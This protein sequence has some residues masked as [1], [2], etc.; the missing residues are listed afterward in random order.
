MSWVPPGSTNRLNSCSEPQ[1]ENSTHRGSSAKPNRLRTVAVEWSRSAENVE[2]PPVLAVPSATDRRCPSVPTTRKTE[3]RSSSLRALV[4]YRPDSVETQNSARRNAASNAE[5]RNWPCGFSSPSG[6]SGK[7]FGSA[8]DRTT[9]RLLALTSHLPLRIRIFRLGADSV[10]TSWQSSFAGTSASTSL[11]MA[12][13]AKGMEMCKW[14]S[15]SV[16]VNSRWR[17][18]EHTSELQ[19]HSDLVCRLLLEKKK[20]K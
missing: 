9:V 5:P 14:L 19:S 6:V 15:K 11:S 3:P 20:K 10:L 16:A 4:L 7:L 13:P 1:V 8:H 2:L 12:S 17:S 18:E